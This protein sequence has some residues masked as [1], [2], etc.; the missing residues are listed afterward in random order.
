MVQLAPREN[1]FLGAGSG[2]SERVP[3]S[4]ETARTIDAEVRR[5]IGES[6]EEAARLLA[7]HRGA[8]DALA[9]ALLE[10]ET[11]DDED[12]LIVTG[13]PPAPRLDP[14]AN[15]ASRQPEPAR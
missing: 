9:S 13:L 4:E 15:G 8:L 14:R 11:L 5:I 3:M 7:K 2:S 1:A 10:R 6:H 12:I